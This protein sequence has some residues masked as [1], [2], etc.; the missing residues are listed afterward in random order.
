[1]GLDRR[2]SSCEI[3]VLCDVDNKLLGPDGAAAVFGPQKG[4]SAD[5]MASLELAL[6][7]FRDVALRK[8]GKDMALLKHGGTAGGFEVG[9][10]LKL[11]PSV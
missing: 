3:V 6:S 1:L 10:L 11:R 8:T 5:D 7:R 9:N 4:A 2:L